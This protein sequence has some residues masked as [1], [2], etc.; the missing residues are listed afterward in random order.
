MTFQEKMLEAADGIRA[1][2][3]TLAQV[4]EKRVGKRVVELKGSLATLSVAG[5]ALEKVARRHGAQFVKQNAT[6]VSAARKDVTSL[7]VTTFGA[8]SKRT[9]APKARKPAA[10]KRVSKSGR[11]RVAAAA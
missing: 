5:R 1:R 10:R 8:L 9:A 11:T 2:A 4:L 7:A 6:I 3:T